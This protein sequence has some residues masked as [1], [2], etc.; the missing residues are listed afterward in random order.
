MTPNNREE[1]GRSARG[2]IAHLF[3]AAQ[4]LTRFTS[5]IAKGLDHLTWKLCWWIHWTKRHIVISSSSPVLIFEE[6]FQSEEE[7]VYSEEYITFME[8]RRIHREKQQSKP[9]IADANDFVSSQEALS[10]RRHLTRN[11]RFS[12]RCLDEHR[13]TFPAV[14]SSSMRTHDQTSALFVVIAPIQSHIGNM[15]RGLN[16]LA[17]ESSI[18]RFLSLELTFENTGLSNTYSPWDDIDLFDV[19]L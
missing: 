11:L 15:A 19:T 3:G 16:A 7:S 9:L 1:F 18:A 17:S 5:D 14:K 4:G 10:S 12:C 13:F 8:L 6:G 2:Y